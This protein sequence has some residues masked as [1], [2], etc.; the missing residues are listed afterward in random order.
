MPFDLLAFPFS[1]ASVLAAYPS[2]VRD[3][4]YQPPAQASEVAPAVAA[5]ASSC[6]ACRGPIGRAR[7]RATPLASQCMECEGRSA[8]R[9]G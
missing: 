1:M 5:V 3:V 4:A 6:V 8:R 2:V 7:L 9:P